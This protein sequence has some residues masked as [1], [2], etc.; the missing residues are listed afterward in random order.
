MFGINTSARKARKAAKKAIYATAESRIS[1]IKGLRDGMYELA[2][3]SINDGSEYDWEADVAEFSNPV[4]TRYTLD[5]Q[6]ATVPIAVPFE[7]DPEKFEDKHKDAIVITRMNSMIQKANTFYDK[8]ITDAAELEAKGFHEAARRK[9]DSAAGYERRINELTIQKTVI[10]DNLGAEAVNALA[11][12]GYAVKNEEA[13]RAMAARAKERRENPMDAAYEELQGVQF[14]DDHRKK[15]EEATNKLY[16]N[17][18]VKLNTRGDALY[19]QIQEKVRRKNDVQ[20]VVS[21]QSDSLE[22]ILAAAKSGGD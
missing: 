21:K 18:T 3:G 6:G 17:E 4:R 13:I 12:D 2:V 11:D 8:C 15:V 14:E 7:G 1:E 16:G 22:A 19:K 5:G 20:A 9:A 10:E